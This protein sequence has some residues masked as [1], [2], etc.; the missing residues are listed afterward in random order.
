MLS[1]LT[2]P[3]RLWAQRLCHQEYPCHQD[4]ALF[5]EA[6]QRAFEP[7]QAVWPNRPPMLPLMSMQWDSVFTLPPV[8]VKKEFT[9]AKHPPKIK[10][11]VTASK[12][13]PVA[14]ELLTPVDVRA[15]FTCIVNIRVSFVCTV[16]VRASY[17]CIVEIRASSACTVDIRASPACTVD[18]RA[19]TAC[20]V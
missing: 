2:G 5:L 4:P 15:R 12:C 9:G 11:E 7:E 18:V 8:A 10:R 16:D 3:A 17:A 6:L 20:T 14:N 19:S 13:P 1:R